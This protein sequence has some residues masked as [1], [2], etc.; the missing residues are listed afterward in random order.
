MEHIDKIYVINM[1]KSSDRLSSITHQIER[2]LK[3]PFIRIG[4]VDGK[5]L[6]SKT[7]NKYTTLKSRSFCSKG[8]IG[9]ALSHYK[10]L[11]KFLK[12]KS[13]YALILEDDC[14]LDSD[15]QYNLSKALIEL[16]ETDPEWKLLYGGYY[17]ITD[18]KYEGIMKMF[19]YFGVLSS[20]KN[21]QGYIGNN[22]FVPLIPVGSYCY[23][24]SRQGAKELLDTMKNKITSPIDVQFIKTFKDST[25][26]YAL[27]NRI[28]HQPFNIE[29]SLVTDSA[30]PK[31]INRLLDELQYK[32]DGIDLS[33]YLNSAVADINDITI[34]G[35]LFSY[36][37]ILLLLRYNNV[38]YKYPAIVIYILLSVE[39]CLNPTSTVLYTVL[40]YMLLFNLI[41]Y[42]TIKN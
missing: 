17:G 6:P 29:Q 34:N 42:N 8:M 13:K 18:R 27:T 2:S 21:K 19:Q 31:T 12:T 24:I 11:K 3:K 33:F 7:Y 40:F 37:G 41:F 30:F 20:I 23:V 14:I 35:Y 10:T 9:C 26:V 16:K 32:I 25:G 28:G 22:T 4:A 36:L 5:N 39:Y 1:K 15:F 38:Y